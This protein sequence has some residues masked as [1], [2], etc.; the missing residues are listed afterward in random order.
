MYEAEFGAGLC[1]AA[2]CARQTYLKN[3]AGPGAIPFSCIALK[4]KHMYCGTVVIMNQI[5]KFGDVRGDRGDNERGEVLPS[6][7][8]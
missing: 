5:A 4:F 8:E 2:F 3:V 6:V 1:M 7:T